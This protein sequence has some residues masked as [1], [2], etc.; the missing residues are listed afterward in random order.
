MV[1]FNNNQSPFKKCLKIFSNTIEKIF[2]LRY[3]I[4]VELSYIE[5]LALNERKKEDVQNC[6]HQRMSIT[7]YQL[8]IMKQL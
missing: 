1:A 3:H 4:L 2:K 7:I 5:K 6:I 8:N